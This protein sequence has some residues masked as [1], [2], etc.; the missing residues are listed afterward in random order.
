MC[1]SACGADPAVQNTTCMLG[2]DGTGLPATAGPCSA[3][4][5]PPALEPCVEAACPP[6]WDQVS[7]PGEGGAQLTLASQPELEDR[8]HAGLGLCCPREAPG[9]RGA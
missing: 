3:D 2:A 9:Q 7:V 6:G 5:K 1:S 8:T 4:E